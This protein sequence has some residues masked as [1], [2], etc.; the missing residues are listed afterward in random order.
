MLSAEFKPTH[1]DWHCL[2]SGGRADIFAL[3]LGLA[4]KYVLALRDTKQPWI[5]H[6]QKQGLPTAD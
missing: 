4:K 1:L 6:L 2:L 3:T 5:E